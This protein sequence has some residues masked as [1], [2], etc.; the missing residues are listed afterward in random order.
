LQALQEC[1]HPDALAIDFEA[2][3]AEE[4]TKVIVQGERVWA[5]SK[6]LPQG[7]AE[8]VG[9]LKF[10]SHGI[11]VLFAK[12]DELLARH[13]HQEMV[14]Y[15]VN[16]IASTYFLAAVPVQGLPWIEIDF[17]EDYQRA[18]EVIYPAIQHVQHVSLALGERG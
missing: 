1:P 7:D 4:E 16:A 15:A 3:L 17:P 10:G 5:L 18:C 11:N 6:A 12:I 2:K 14:P 13:H 9:M 8:N